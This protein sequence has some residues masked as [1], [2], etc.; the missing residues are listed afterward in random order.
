MQSSQDPR[1]PLGMGDV[2]PVQDRAFRFLAELEAQAALEDVELE[3]KVLPVAEQEQ[4]DIAPDEQEVEQLRELFERPAGLT[5]RF[6]P[7]QAPWSPWSKKPPTVY[8]VRSPA[9]PPASQRWRRPEAAWELPVKATLANAFAPVFGDGRPLPETF[10]VTS[11]EFPPWKQHLPE[12]QRSKQ[13]KK[14]TDEVLSPDPSLPSDGSP[15]LHSDA[16]S[17]TFFN[18]PLKPSNQVLQP[19]E[20]TPTHP[21][22]LPVPP[23]EPKAHSPPVRG[24]SRSPS[25]DKSKRPAFPRRP[26][27]SCQ[28]WKETEPFVSYATWCQ[29]KVARRKTKK[30]DPLFQAELASDFVSVPIDIGFKPL[31]KGLGKPG[32]PKLP[33]K[34]QQRKAQ[35]EAE[36]PSSEISSHPMEAPDTASSEPVVKSKLGLSP[37]YD[38][39]ALKDP[40]S[41]ALLCFPWL[42]Q[43]WEKVQTSPES[44]QLLPPPQ[45]VS[46]TSAAL[47]SLRETGEP[48]KS[49]RTSKRD[50]GARKLSSVV[51]RPPS[52]SG[53]PPSQFRRGKERSW[54]CR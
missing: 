46:G 32:M 54:R 25:P 26:F 29:T 38:P 49:N 24:R 30:A 21:A 10:L 13:N 15:T 19:P 14:S 34:T 33:P 52:Q 2:Q 8:T 4:P 11:S 3:S 50:R 53:S 43:L 23:P 47:F 37:L 22:P 20:P 6:A 45:L 5:Q 41:A 16:S 51:E 9:L 48:G 35:E 7:P 31:P 18:S 1:A 12:A 28:N 17:P 40:P 36:E 27:I 42:S 39:E 44:S